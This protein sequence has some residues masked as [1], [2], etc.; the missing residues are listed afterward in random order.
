[1]E[2]LQ[3]YHWPGNVR[4][5]RNVIEHAMILSRN[6][7]L[8]ISMPGPASFE[9]PDN[10]RLDAVERRH[11]MGVLKRTGWRVAGKGGA[12]DALGLKRTTLYSKMKKL[13]ID[14]PFVK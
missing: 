13:G 14:R 3:C 9:P 6:K 10:S 5:L 4:E 11:I 1:M 2:A 7:N 8:V 12:A